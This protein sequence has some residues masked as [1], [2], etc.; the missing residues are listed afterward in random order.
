MLRHTA[1]AGKACLHQP[2]LHLSIQS[3]KLAQN[4][5]MVFSVLPWAQSCE[6]SCIALLVLAEHADHRNQQA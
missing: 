1:A 6:S 3:L 4:L 2:N 5:K